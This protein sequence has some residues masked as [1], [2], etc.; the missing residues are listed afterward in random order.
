MYNYSNGSVVIAQ[1]MNQSVLRI[2]FLE[3]IVLFSSNCKFFTMQRKLYTDV[4][5]AQTFFNGVEE[6]KQKPAVAQTALEST[7]RK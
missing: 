3:L 4:T 7:L 2:H 1:I 6:C 5:H